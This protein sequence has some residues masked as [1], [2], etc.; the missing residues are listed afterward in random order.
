MNVSSV[1][2]SNG[3]S[4]DI[5]AKIKQLETQLK[6]IQKQITEENQSDDDAETKQKTIQLLQTQETQIYAEIQQIRNQG[7]QKQQEKQS[8]ESAV[9]NSTAVR[10]AGKGNHVNVSV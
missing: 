6:N 4:S 8:Q 9:E 5:E 10:E 2:C 1:S 7:S 3:N